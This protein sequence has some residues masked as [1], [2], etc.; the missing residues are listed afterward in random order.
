M[1]RSGLSAE[2]RDGN[3]HAVEVEPRW[4]IVRGAGSIDDAGR[5]VP[6]RAGAAAV[7]V[8]SGRLAAE[9]EVNVVPGPLASIVVAPARANVASD[10]TRA[11]SAAGRDAHGNLVDIDPA[12]SVTY[13]VGSLDAEGRFT[14]TMVGTGV[15]SATSGGV[16][17]TADVTTTPGALVALEVQPSAGEVR[18]GELLQFRTTGLD[19]RGNA[20]T[21][22][23]IEWRVTGDVGTVDPARGVFTALAAGAGQVLARSSGVEGATDIRVVPADPSADTSTVEVSAAPASAGGDPAEIVV[24]VRDAFSNPVAGAPVRVV[25]SRAADTVQPVESVTG[26]D[27]EIRLQITSGAARAL[28]APGDRGDGGVGLA[29]ADRVP[30]TRTCRGPVAPKAAGSLARALAHPDHHGCPRGSREQFYAAL[31]LCLQVFAWIEGRRELTAGTADPRA[32]RRDRRSGVCAATLHGAPGL[33]RSRALVGGRRLLGR[34]RFR[35]NLARPVQGRR[36]GAARSP[37]GR[38]LAGGGPRRGGAVVEGAVQL[39]N[40]EAGFPDRHGMLE[41]HGLDLPFEPMPGLGGLD[42]LPIEGQPGGGLAQL[43]VELPEGAARGQPPRHDDE[44]EPH[45][46][47]GRRDLE[48]PGQVR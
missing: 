46:G 13:G 33:R 34:V 41:L 4:E 18:S 30:L 3:G 37:A 26:A 9:A 1:N 35:Q 31:L 44:Q 16:V 23:P 25:S 39:S 21:G 2:G 45:R 48:I 24:T 47:E 5:F 12:W 28:E 27:G 38:R 10:A 43:E 8:T 40:P 29:P 19:A 36:G 42:L 14:G 17:G 11:F 20:V 22:Y 15:V 6:T 7:R 32:R